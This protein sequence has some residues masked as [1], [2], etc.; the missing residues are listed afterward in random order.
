MCEEDAQIYIQFKLVYSIFYF[1]YFSMILTLCFFVATPHVEHM[2][3]KLNMLEMSDLSACAH[4]LGEGAHKGNFSLSSL[5]GNSFGIVS[6]AGFCLLGSGYMND[7]TT[8]R[9]E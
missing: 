2:L 8:C 5:K 6:P 3:G 9:S 7:Y 4:I 1:F